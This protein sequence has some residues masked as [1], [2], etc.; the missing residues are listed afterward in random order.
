MYFKTAADSPTGL[1]YRFLPS[2]SPGYC[3]FVQR[4]YPLPL[5][6]LQGGMTAL[7]RV[8]IPV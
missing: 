6:M 4:A 8:A 3:Y 1:A 2:Q 7:W 5:E